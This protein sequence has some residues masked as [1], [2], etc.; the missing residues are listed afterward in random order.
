MTTT[1]RRIPVTAASCTVNG[2]HFG[3]TSPVWR[4]LWLPRARRRER[5]TLMLAVLGKAAPPDHHL[6]V[7]WWHPEDG[8]HPWPP[9]MKYRVRPK[10]RYRAW[11]FRRIG[12]VW[13]LE[14]PHA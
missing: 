11:H 12:G 6:D 7:P 13:H 4:G 9:E 14:R 10:H 3:Q 1:P 8:P 5:S 2:S